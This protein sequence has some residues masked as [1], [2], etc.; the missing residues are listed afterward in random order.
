MVGREGR[1]GEG[2]GGEGRGRV[3]L[4]FY[5][6]YVHSYFDLD[7]PDLANLSAMSHSSEA[8]NR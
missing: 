7:L 4:N 6:S 1:G 8:E 2:K 3:A 5:T